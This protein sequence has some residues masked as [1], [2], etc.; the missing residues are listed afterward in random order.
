MRTKDVEEAAALMKPARAGRI[1]E[2]ASAEAD[3]QLQNEGAL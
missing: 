1:P 3:E 2:M